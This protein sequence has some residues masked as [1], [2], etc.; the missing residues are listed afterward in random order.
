[1]QLK[2][3][4]FLKLVAV[5]NQLGIAVKPF[6]WVAKWLVWLIPPAVS[7]RWLVKLALKLIVE[8][9]KKSRADADARFV[10]EVLKTVHGGGF[11]MFKDRI[12]LQMCREPD[13]EH[14]YYSN[15]AHGNMS[16]MVYMLPSGCRLWFNVLAGSSVV[17]SGLLQPGESEDE[18]FWKQP[19]P[20]NSSIKEKE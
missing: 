4:Y 15:T 18:M 3:C 20:D 8:L 2:A 16:V 9:A 11:P 6:L 12:I 1:M 5:A 14:T 19:R 13:E 17:G 10:M 7:P